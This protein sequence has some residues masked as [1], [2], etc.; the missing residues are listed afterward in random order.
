MQYTYQVKLGDS[1]DHYVFE[2]FKIYKILDKYLRTTHL[3]L[4]FLKKIPFLLEM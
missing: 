2:I 4:D 1:R 3:T